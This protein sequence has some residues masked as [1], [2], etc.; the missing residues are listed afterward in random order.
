MSIIFSNYVFFRTYM[1]TSKQYT[2]PRKNVLTNHTSIHLH[3]QEHTSEPQHVYT[4]PPN[5]K[6]GKLHRVDPFTPNLGKTLTKIVHSL[7]GS[8]EEVTLV[9]VS[10][11][12]KGSAPKYNAP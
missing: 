1:I 7:D 8:E 4:R 9:A 3:P 5:N 2:L 6:A 12:K 10:K 11:A